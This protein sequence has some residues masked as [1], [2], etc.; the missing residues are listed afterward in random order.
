MDEDAVVDTTMAEK[1]FRTDLRKLI[2]LC[3]TSQK[4]IA[5]NELHMSQAQM[6][7][8][9]N[10]TDTGWDFYE[11]IVGSCLTRI[12]PERPPRDMPRAWTSLAH[13]EA[14]FAAARGAR[15]G[16]RPAPGS[17][18][19]PRPPLREEPAPPTP[20]VARAVT[21]GPFHRR[22]AIA[23]AAVLGVALI[24]G[25]IVLLLNQTA[26]SVDSRAEP[27]LAL[28]GT[29]VGPDTRWRVTSSGFTPNGRY[30]V[31]VFLPD[32]SPYEL[33]GP[34]DFGSEGTA[35]SDGSL[36]TT[37]ACYA[38]DPE[39]TYTMTVLDETTHKTA[40]A[41]FFVDKPN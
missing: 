19:D 35:K 28:S 6:S 3:G 37:W 27:R 23:A 12:S 34:G 26:Q 14:Q 4:E 41:K 29:C 5:E 21:A 33:G 1:V 17:P 2:R 13:W 8:Q 30:T 7:R 40:T 39:G 9:I 36:N 15:G 32:G 25:G 10:A 22:G 20:A 24:A 18:P 11:K 31:K 16:D 38:P